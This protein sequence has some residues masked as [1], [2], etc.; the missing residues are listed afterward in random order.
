MNP[1]LAAGILVLIVLVLYIVFVKLPA[2]Q[3]MFAGHEDG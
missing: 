3:G 2:D 1:W